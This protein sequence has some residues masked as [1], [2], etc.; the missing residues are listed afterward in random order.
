MGNGYQLADVE[1]IYCGLQNK[2]PVIIIIYASLQ[3]DGFNV[4]CI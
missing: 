3:A 4:R 2:T 1:S